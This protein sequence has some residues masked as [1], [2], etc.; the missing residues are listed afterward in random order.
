MAGDDNRLFLD[1]LYGGAADAAE[2]ERAL[3]LLS[4]QMS[5]QSAALVALDSHAPAAD[6]V[7]SVGVFDED[8]RMRY[9]RD[10]ASIDPAPSAF[11]RLPK[12]MV[13][14]TDRMLS[15]EQLRSGV[16]VNEFY[17]PLGLAET[18]GANLRSDNGHFE[19]IGL[20]RGH[21]RDRFEDAELAEVE[22]LIP[23][24][25]RALQLRR[26]FL[27]LEAKSASLQDMVDRLSAGV[28]LLDASGTALF[29]NHAM[30]VIAARGDGFSLSRA[31]RPI[32]ANAKARSRFDGLLKSV[33]QGDAGGSLAV[34]RS[35]GIR[36]Y[37]V[38]V[39]P[40]PRSFAERIRERRLPACAIVLVHDPAAQQ[41]SDPQLLQQ[42]LGLP[43]GAARLVAALAGDDDLK[44]F[45]GRE[46]VTIHAARFHL[47]TA[48]ARTGARTQAELVRLA[49][50]LLRDLGLRQ[51]RNSRS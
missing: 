19:L 36:P 48:F 23:H 24:F 20:Q 11:A 28:A 32:P 44:S 18:L 12:G 7:V 22:R 34:P 40:S 10:F 31:G 25:N 1:A 35:T 4:D 45:A 37:A 26:A 21:D 15:A 43:P 51:T 8:A 6:L 50:A 47:R 38:L 46:G 33:M 14:T 9:A 17:Y 30:C 42:G 2:F 29:I 41:L 13:S 27:P 39:A 3:T 16:F 49:V 5:C